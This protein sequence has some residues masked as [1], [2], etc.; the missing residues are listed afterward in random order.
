MGKYKYSSI[1]HRA[2][3]IAKYVE[4]KWAMVWVVQRNGMGG[5][6]EEARK[7]KGGGDIFMICFKTSCIVESM[8]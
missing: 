1:I 6:R 3:L 4:E 7:K 8:R 2:R 5:E